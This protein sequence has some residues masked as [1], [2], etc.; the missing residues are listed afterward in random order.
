MLANAGRERQLVEVCADDC[1]EKVGTLASEK[2]PSITMLRW[3]PIAKF[4]ITSW[5]NPASGSISADAASG[6]C[7][8]YCAR[9]G[10]RLAIRSGSILST[11]ESSE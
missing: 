4:W 2:L 7:S 3:C 11:Q 1:C 9:S 6:L 5:R 10:N 8:R